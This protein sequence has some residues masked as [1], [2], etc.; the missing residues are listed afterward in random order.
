MSVVPH[1][2]S[3]PRTLCKALFMNIPGIRRHLVYYCWF[4]LLAMFLL[5]AIHCKFLSKQSSPKHLLNISDDWSRTNDARIQCLKEQWHVSLFY[6]NGSISCD[7]TKCVSFDEATGDFTESKQ[8]PA[9]YVRCPRYPVSAPF[10]LPKT[11]L[12]SWPGS[13]NTWM[14]HILQ[15]LTGNY[16]ISSGGSC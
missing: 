2:W 7:P 5:C 4:I 14:R 15:Q 9:S 6:N 10:R 8:A 1:P 16:N 11:G 13:G 3:C 12:V